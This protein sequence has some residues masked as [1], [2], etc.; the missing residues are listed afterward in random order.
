MFFFRIMVE[1]KELNIKNTENSYHEIALALEKYKERETCSIRFIVEGDLK[2][3]L[4]GIDY[5]GRKM[6]KRK[7][8]SQRKNI[9]RWAN[10]F[11]FRVVPY[12]NGEA[13]GPE[14]F[15]FD[16][17]LRDFKDNKSE[18]EEFWKMLQELYRTN[19][20]NKEPPKLKGMDSKTFLL[21]LKWIWIEEDFNYKFKWED[22]QSK[23]KYV[24]AKISKKTGKEQP[25]SRGAG[26]AKFFAALILLKRK[27]FTYEEVKKIIPLFN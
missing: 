7:L 23:T 19:K 17:F 2:K 11:D 25:V 18:N 16:K 5:P 15:T 27:D 4:V 10:L 8:K 13:L 24:L 3:P 1:I 6:F 21:T 22:I 20:I 14:K 26:R 9:A 12:E